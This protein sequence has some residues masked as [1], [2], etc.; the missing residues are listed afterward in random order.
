MFLRRAILAAAVCGTLTACADQPTGPRASA[1]PVPAPRRTWLTGYDSPFGV[2]VNQTNDPSFGPAAQQ[3]LKDGGI[4]WIRIDVR[5]EQI[6]ASGS[7]S[8]D[9]SS[10]DSTVSYAN[11]RGIQVL[12]T[13]AYTPG[14]ANGNSGPGVAPYSITDWSNFVSAATTRYAGKVQA[15]T[16]WNEPNHTDFFQSRNNF[17]DYDSLVAAAVGPVHTAGATLV[18]GEMAYGASSSACTTP[19]PGHISWMNARLNANPSID[20]FSVHL[21]AKGSCAVHMMDAAD[22][23]MVADKP[24]WLTEYGTANPN[25][26]TATEGTWQADNL[27]DVYQGMATRTSFWKKT[28]QYHLYLDDPNFYYGILKG[29]S[30]VE[31]PAFKA[32]R[33][34]A[35]GCTGNPD[36]VGVHRWWKP[37]EHLYTTDPNEGYPFGYTLEFTNNFHLSRENLGSAK[38]V[39]IYRCWRHNTG[40]QHFLTTSATCDGETNVTL[41]SL[42]MYGVDAP[43]YVPGSDMIPLYRLSYTPNG[44]D[45]IVTTV[46]DRNALVSAGWTDRGLLAYGWL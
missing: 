20:V 6:Q 35:N 1:P 38:M 9:W 15:W 22:A 27:W 43:F 18:A 4:G 39:E 44:D 42:G 40:N 3:K 32:L 26:D 29:T 36:C 46:A 13:L 19:E 30:L 41:E 31:R 11:S 45:I 37:A 23:Q 2:N 16:I 17:A 8:F 5:W 7:S 25:P 24:I 21:Y 10:V 33:L 28:F 34:I 14:W 12:G